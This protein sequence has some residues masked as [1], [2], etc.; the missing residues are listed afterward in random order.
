LRRVPA[1]G[2]WPGR[3]GKR[4]VSVNYQTDSAIYVSRRGFLWRRN[5]VSPR[6]RNSDLFWIEVVGAA[7]APVAC[8][9]PTAL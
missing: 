2:G 7:R 9:S 3:L 6:A 1:R 5:P 4:D 8:G